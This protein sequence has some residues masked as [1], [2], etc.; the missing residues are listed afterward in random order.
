MSFGAIA[1]QTTRLEIEEVVRNFSHIVLSNFLYEMVH[2]IGQH[3]HEHVFLDGTDRRHIGI[4]P[5][6][7]VDWRRILAQSRKCL[8][9][10]FMYRI[11][12]LLAANLTVSSNRDHRQLDFAK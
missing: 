2:F 9:E 6:Y 3:T 5:K 8:T 1:P 7:G 4:R 10:R 11:I 12:C